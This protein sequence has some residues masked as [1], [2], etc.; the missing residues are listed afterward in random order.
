MLAPKILLISALIDRELGKLIYAYFEVEAIVGRRNSN[1]HEEFF[2]S[3]DPIS[4][5]VKVSHLTAIRKHRLLPTVLHHVTSILE[6][7]VVMQLQITADMTR[8]DFCFPY[9]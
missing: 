3:I 9:L 1:G 2:I 4:R 6:A 5:Q 8:D 7:S